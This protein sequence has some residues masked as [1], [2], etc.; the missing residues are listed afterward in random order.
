[1]PIDKN[2]PNVARESR[3]NPQRDVVILGL[4]NFDNSILLVRTT[5]FPD[6]WQPIG[7][8]MRE[9]DKSPIDA[10]KRELKEESHID[11]PLSK[12]QFEIETKYDFGKG[13]VYFY[14]ARLQPDVVLKFDKSEINEWRWFKIKDALSLK[15]FPATRKFIEHLLHRM[16]GKLTSESS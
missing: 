5:R 12:I 10:V 8:G 3:V 16:E 11:L 14:T 2:D 1:M 9:S 4:I 6:H 13:K 7:G 15:M